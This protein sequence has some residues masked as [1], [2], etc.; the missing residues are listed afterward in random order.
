MYVCVYNTLERGAYILII[1]FEKS[2]SIQSNKPKQLPR[3]SPTPPLNHSITIF[4][5][6]SSATVKANFQTGYLEIV[7][8]TNGLVPTTQS[9]ILTPFEALLFLLSNDFLLTVNFSGILPGPSV[10]GCI[11]AIRT[12]SA[13]AVMVDRSKQLMQL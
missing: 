9:F 13:N 8:T 12:I 11:N 6:I 4:N 3:S 1:N 10:I 5:E 7:H 2:R